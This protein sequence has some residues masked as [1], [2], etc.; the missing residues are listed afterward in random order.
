MKRF[1]HAELQ[2]LHN[3]LVLMGEKALES[4]R[5]SSECL[6]Q[7]NAELAGKVFLLDDEID[8]LEMR[9]DAESIRYITL[10]APVAADVRMLTVA[11]KINHE[12]ERIGD[13]A[14]SIARKAHKMADLPWSLDVLGH[15]PQMSFLVQSLLRDAL[16][17]FI[18]DDSAKALEL[19]KRDKEIDRLNKENYDNFA[20]LMGK[21]AANPSQVIDLVFISKS[22]ERIGDHATNIAEE[23]VYLL[24]GEDV[25]HSPE[26]K[27]TNM[28]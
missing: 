7:K 15:L 4:V 6:I 5:L 20:E 21:R 23:V 1:F 27:R 9:I 25:R 8:E 10:R 26:V 28:E 24:R 12:L 13:E 11:M 2:D 18:Q 17:T 16:D 19:P 3:H 14:T 22:F